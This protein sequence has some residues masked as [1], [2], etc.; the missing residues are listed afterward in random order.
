MT[1]SLHGPHGPVRALRRK[2][3]GQRHCGALYFDLMNIDP[4]RPRMPDRDRFV[5][6]K[7]HA[8]P[9]LYA[10]LALRGYFPVAEL[11]TLRKNASRLQGHPVSTYLPGWMP[12]PAPWAWA[13]P[14]PSA[15]PWKRK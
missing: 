15:W 1:A 6:S 5:L 4:A 2:P 10:A 13:L 12:P 9:V 11:S 3:F 8:C 14:R 7:G